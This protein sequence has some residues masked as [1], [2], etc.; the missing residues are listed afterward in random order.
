MVLEVKGMVLRVNG[1]MLGV[2]GMCW[3]EGH[4]GRIGWHGIGSEWPGESA[5]QLSDLGKSMESSCGIS[6][7]HL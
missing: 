4:G 7:K 6:V 5:E 3:G 2:N 1:T